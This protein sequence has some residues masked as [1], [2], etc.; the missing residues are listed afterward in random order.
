MSLCAKMKFNAASCGFDVMLV[1]LD[2][3]MPSQFT[4]HVI[5]Y[6]LLPADC[7]LCTIFIINK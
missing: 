3:F 4:L 1:L 2:R 5:A 7:V 6:Y